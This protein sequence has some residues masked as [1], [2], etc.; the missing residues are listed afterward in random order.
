M[1]KLQGDK[2]CLD[3]RQLTLLLEGIVPLKTKRRFNR[4]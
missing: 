1:P 2:V 4:K 3:R